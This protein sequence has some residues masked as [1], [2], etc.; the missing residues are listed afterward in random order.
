MG[1]PP[2]SA[3][4]TEGGMVYFPRMLDKMRKL[5][6]GELREDFHEHVGKGRDAVC[7]HFLRVDY[8]KLRERV[9]AGATDAEAWAWCAE[10][11]RAVDGIDIQIWNA[12]ATKFGWRDKATPYLEK[13]KAESGLAGREDLQTMFEYFEVDEG[14]KG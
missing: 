4:E 6:A 5:A 10:H 8:A 2:I 3:Y 14:R 12:Y 11:G 9:L 7:C 1:T 13:V